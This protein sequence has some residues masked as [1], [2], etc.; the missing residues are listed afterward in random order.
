MIAV[1]ADYTGQT[2]YLGSPISG[3][4]VRQSLTD[5]DYIRRVTFNVGLVLGVS[6]ASLILAHLCLAGLL[7]PARS[8]KPSPDLS[9]AKEA[10]FITSGRHSS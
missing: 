1:D 10:A 9:I 6:S 3:A 8:Y 4:Y 5:V 7:Q 2:G